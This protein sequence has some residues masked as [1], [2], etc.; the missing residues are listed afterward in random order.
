[1]MLLSHPF[2]LPAVMAQDL[3]RLLMHWRELRR[4][5]NEMPFADDIRIE[6][7]PGLRSRLFLLDVFA[8]PER[9]RIG[10]VGK[11]VAA[12]WLEGRFCDEIACDGHL[13]YL[14]AQASATVEAKAPTFYREDAAATRFSRLLLPA[15]G[16]GRVSLLL[17][18]VGF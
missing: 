16:E 6:T 15:W 11:D 8:N 3:V 13:T 12:P 14:R 9:I 2:P 10:L 4:A 18:A 17:G 7:I 1:M 5:G